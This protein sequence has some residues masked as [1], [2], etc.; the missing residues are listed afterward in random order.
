MPDLHTDLH[1]D[2]HTVL[3]TVQENS[4]NPAHDAFVEKKS[5][6]IGN[7]CHVTTL[8]EAVDFVQS[9]KV[10]NPKARHVA[11]AAICGMRGAQLCERMSDD[12][13]PAGTAGK[14]ILDVLRSANLTDCVVT[15]TRYFG[16]ILLGSGGLTRA[17]ARSASMAV[18][19]AKIVDIVSCISFACN[20][21][22]QQLRMLQHIV[23]QV[24]GVIDSENYG[25]D[26]TL[27]ISVPTYKSEEFLLL[28]KNAF[29]GSVVPEVL[30]RK[31][32]VL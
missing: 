17:Y 10:A 16:G 7:I 31:Q 4:S 26:I 29:S 15:V 8:D 11:Y 25:A 30:C 27:N 23:N 9:V 2:S 6:F 19:A 1:T 5:E 24:E 12:G 13:E 21:K 32:M 22:Y 18:A 14:P 3:H 28:V 20:L